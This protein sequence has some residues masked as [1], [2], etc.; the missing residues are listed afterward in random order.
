VAARLVEQMKATGERANGRWERLKA[1]LPLRV[2]G[3][4]ASGVSPA[5]DAELVRNP[6]N[7]NRPNV[8]RFER[9]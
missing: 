1:Q 3:R 8:K 9:S 6:P 2:R 5:D 4:R 7:P